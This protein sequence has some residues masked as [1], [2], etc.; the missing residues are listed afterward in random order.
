M[1][2]KGV[3]CKPGHPCRVTL[4]FNTAYFR[5]ARNHRVRLQVMVSP[6]DTHG[7]IASDAPLDLSPRH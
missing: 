7:W 3:P 4:R 6:K 5:P 2:G 1:F